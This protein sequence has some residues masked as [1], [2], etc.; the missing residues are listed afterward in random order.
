VTQT[1]PR[2]V[3]AKGALTTETKLFKRRCCD[4]TDTDGVNSAKANQIL[5]T[6]VT[7]STKLL[8]NEAPGHPAPHLIMYKKEC[9][10]YEVLAMIVITL[11]SVE[12]FIF[13]GGGGEVD[14]F[15]STGPAA[16]DA[17]TRTLGGSGLMVADTAAA[18]TAAAI[19]GGP[20][21]LGA[22]G[23]GGPGP[24][25]TGNTTR[26]CCCGGGGAWDGAG[27]C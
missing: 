15:S 27:V 4:V 10:K 2:Q 12:V 5:I 23:A 14:L 20:G 1:S 18:G 17:E 25:D 8:N 13:F 26:C 21:A 24:D 3:C 9:S 19:E 7:H 6:G 16:V 11:G 22:M